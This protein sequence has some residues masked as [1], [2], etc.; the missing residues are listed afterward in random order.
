[1]RFCCGTMSRAKS[2]L[3]WSVIHCRVAFG[4]HYGRGS[5]YSIARLTNF[6]C[7][8][9]NIRGEFNKFEE[10]G[11]YFYISRCVFHICAV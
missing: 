2:S 7:A 9:P 5:E 4:W 6:I 10:L 1:M 11:F 8:L 3:H